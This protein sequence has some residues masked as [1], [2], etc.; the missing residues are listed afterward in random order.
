MNVWREQWLQE[1]PANTQSW[2]RIWGH[3]GW[4]SR[5][6]AP[7]LG[8]IGCP[9]DC[10]QPGQEGHELGRSWWVPGTEF[11]RT[12]PSHR[13]THCYRCPSPGSG[14]GGKFG[15]FW[16]FLSLSRH[17]FSH[18]VHIIFHLEGQRRPTLG[19]EGV[20][21][22]PDSRNRPLRGRS[23]GTQGSGMGIGAL[24]IFP[25]PPN[26]SLSFNPLEGSVGVGGWGKS[27]QGAWTFQGKRLYPAPEG[28]LNPC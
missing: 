26:S 6:A 10:G 27:Q 1:L 11:V 16:L 5:L 9:G 25:H 24:G 4:G 8:L 7:V 13:S 22:F 21:G 17:I 14:G 19:T 28:H 15:L 20:T 23:D 2:G 12:P 3:S 18:E